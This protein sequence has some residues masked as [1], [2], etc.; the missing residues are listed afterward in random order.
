MTDLQEVLIR[1]SEKIIGYYKYLLDT[2][3]SDAER[4]R[5]RRRI[6]EEQRLLDKLRRS[7]QPP[8]T[9]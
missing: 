6:D 9:A 7:G 1:G 8:R 5:F 4:E 3:T 2:A